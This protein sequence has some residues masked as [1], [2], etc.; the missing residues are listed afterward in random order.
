MRMQCPRCSDGC[1]SRLCYS[2]HRSGCQVGWRVGLCLLSCV[3]SLGFGICCLCASR[4]MGPALVLP[5]VYVHVVWCVTGFRC[6]TGF[7]VCELLWAASR[8]SCVCGAQ[9]VQMGARVVHAAVC[10]TAAASWATGVCRRFGSGNVLGCDCCGVLC[11]QGY[12]FNAHVLL[13]ASVSFM[14]QYALQ[15]LPGT[16]VW[17]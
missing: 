7:D 11:H 2:M 3:M 5:A 17:V 13:R 6:V 16:L 12:V 15:R 10:T 14:L 4:G 1:Q 9:D 8:H